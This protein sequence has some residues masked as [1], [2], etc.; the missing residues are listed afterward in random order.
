M[1]PRRRG[2]TRPPPSGMSSIPFVNDAQSLESQ[3]G[4]QLVEDR[5]EIRLERQDQSPRA[6]G[7]HPVPHL[8]PHPL[9]DALY[10]GDVAMEQTGLEAVGGGATDDVRRSPD[11]HPRQ[12]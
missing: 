9:E 5:A 7:P 10:E 1:P 6:D 8:L 11:V 12:P 3:V 4:V 2:S